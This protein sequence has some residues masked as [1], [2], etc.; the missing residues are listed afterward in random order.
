MSKYVECQI[1]LTNKEFKD[2]CTQLG[3]SIGNKVRLWQELIE[4]DVS[5]DNRCGIK[6]GKLVFDDMIG[7]STANRIIE[8]WITNRAKEVFGDVDIKRHEDSRSI[9]L[10]IRR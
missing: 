4:V 9:R 1:S 10:S 8:T 5:A 6:D 2:I 3:Y 7:A